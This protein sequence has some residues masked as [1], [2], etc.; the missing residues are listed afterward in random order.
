M[1]SIKASQDGLLSSLVAFEEAAAVLVEAV[2]E[3][4]MVD[5]RGWVWL[6]AGA[7]VD[8]LKTGVSLVLL[9][10]APLETVAVEVV[11][12]WLKMMPPLLLL[13]LLASPCSRS[14]FCFLSCGMADGRIVRLC[15]G[16]VGGVGRGW[17]EAC[18]GGVQSVRGVIVCCA[19]FKKARWRGKDDGD[20]QQGK[21]PPTFLEALFATLARSRTSQSGSKD[22]DELEN[23]YNEF[24]CCELPCLFFVGWKG[25]VWKGGV[26]FERRTHC[27]RRL[28]RMV[29]LHVPRNKQILIHKRQKREMKGEKKSIQ[30]KKRRAALPAF[31]QQKLNLGSVKSEVSVCLLL[32]FIHLLLQNHST[33]SFLGYSYLSYY[34]FSMVINHSAGLSVAQHAP[35]RA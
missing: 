19:L 35:C 32:C 28:F 5:G 10:S 9:A 12:C 1:S 2:G 25:N 8:V 11:G 29:L 27:R 6:A 21:T 16:S 20:L 24:S 15:C 30:E 22:K 18:A 4:A 17:R 14:R 23:C 31:T 3:V 33:F 34:L 13:L 26:R 7:I